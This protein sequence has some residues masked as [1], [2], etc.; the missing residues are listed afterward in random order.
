MSFENP[1]GRKLSFIYYFGILFILSST[2]VSNKVYDYISLITGAIII[3]S[4][5]IYVIYHG[6]NEYIITLAS[7]TITVI[8]ILM[9]LTLAFSYL[10][11]YHIN[12][13]WTLV[14]ALT[15]FLILSMLAIIF[16]SLFIMDYLLDYYGIEEHSD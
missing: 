4:Y 1:A 10:W 6:D 8:F 16:P 2:I 9:P 15:V 7:M 11:R 12:S 3:I 5:W 14:P 13:I